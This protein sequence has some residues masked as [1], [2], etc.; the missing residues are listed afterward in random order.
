M[1]Q[2][3]PYFPYILNLPNELLLII[4]EHLDDHNLMYLATTCIRLNSLFL[5]G[6]YMS[7]GLE[8]PPPSGALQTITVTDSESLKLLSVMAITPSVKSIELLDSVPS[9]LPTLQDHL[10]AVRSLK[11]LAIR[12]SHL[13]HV[14]LNPYASA[15]SADKLSDWLQSLA[16]F[17]NSA[18]RRGDCS[19][20]VYSQYGLG[21]DADLR[22][23]LHSFP[24]VTA[25]ISPTAQSVERAGTQQPIPR[26]AAPCVESTDRLG[27]TRLPFASQAAL[28]C[29]EI[30]SS[31]LFHATFYKWTAHTLDTAPIT[32][33][34]LDRIDLLHYDWTLTLPL[35]TLSALTTLTIGQCAIPVPDLTLFLAR[36][37]GIQ[38]LDL[39]FHLAIGPLSPRSLGA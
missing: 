26:S 37:P 3:S 20:S 31:L 16:A 21:Y 38:T 24:R 4:S 17:L 28:K 2:S 27:V 36:H 9:Q 14:R 23:F 10:L 33:L 30:H 12:L 8:P 13:G 5:P 1:S 39:S 32:T 35:L 25:P 11:S 15:N 34:S 19:I 18:V 7:F 22:P 6:L 29:L